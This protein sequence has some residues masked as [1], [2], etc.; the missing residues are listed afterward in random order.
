MAAY[1]E[2]LRIAIYFQVDFWGEYDS[3]IKANLDEY[4][5]EVLKQPNS[6]SILV[7]TIYIENALNVYHAR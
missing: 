7:E 5:E 2:R 6:P 3:K 4:I 1:P